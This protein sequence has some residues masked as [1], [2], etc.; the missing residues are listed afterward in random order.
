M[1]LT[2][3]LCIACLIW[4]GLLWRA[5]A[6]DC[7][8]SGQL[9]RETHRSELTGRARAYSLYLP[10]CFD[11]VNGS[12][13]LLT[14]LHGSNAD[15][16]QWLRL[17]AIAEL[18]ARILRG[19]S[20]PLLLLL[21]DGGAAANENRFDA[22][23]YGASLLELMER[24]AESA[25]AENRWAIGGISRGGFWAYHLGLRY[26]ERFVAIGGHSAYFDPRHFDAPNNP[27]HLARELPADTSLR[28]WLDRGTRDH[29]ASGL[30]RMHNLLRRR[31]V[32]HDYV[33][34]AGGG[35][36][37]ASWRAHVSEYLDFY[38]A[39]LA[40]RDDAKRAG[41][42]AITDG[43]ELW[44]PA[45]GFPTL[46]TSIA[47]AELEAVLASQH[48]LRLVMSADAAERLRER[49]I[50][51][52]ADTRIVPPG[53]LTNHLWRDKLAYTLLPFDALHPRLRSL[54]LD[55]RPI[56]AQLDGY[57]LV[58]ESDAPNFSPGRLTRI[59][60]SGTTA[61]AR[62]TRK[63]VDRMG[64][65]DASSGISDYTRESDFFGMTSEATIAPGC[66]RFTGIEL[67][68][69]NSL[70]MKHEHGGLFAALGADVIDLTGNHINDYGY[71]AFA[72]YA[73]FLRRAG[74][75]GGR[76]RT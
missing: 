17:G 44:L 19:D 73:G 70:C 43:V 37:E 23:G 18:E 66:P 69:A 56:V 65:G 67:G 61:I 1:P 51:L 57:P 68:G 40:G 63:A 4:V 8:E 30:D 42:A 53:Q 31:G 11:A 71:G 10:P 50:A 25:G 15:D 34:Y 39:A 55:D 41:R 36:D 33:V 20:P 45:G 29:A 14:L 5:R 3:I 7:G 52:H 72:E 35:H 59:T 54:W 2:R 12:Y 26:P 76:R 28:L 58:F 6:L 22:T 74:D 49:G 46:R 75:G 60:L 32:A 16:Q 48:D 9:L 13:P 47:R 38:V 62:A 24:V 64:I 21:P 27:L